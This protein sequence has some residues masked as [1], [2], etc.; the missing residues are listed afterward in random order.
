MRFRYAAASAGFDSGPVGSSFGSALPPSSSATDWAKSNSGRP[1]FI[2]RLIS[3]PTISM[4]LISLVPS[5][6]RLI[7]ASR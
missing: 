1:P 5:K 7:R 3:M 2:A 4:R 6:M